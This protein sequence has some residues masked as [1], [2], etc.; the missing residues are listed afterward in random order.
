MPGE[1]DVLDRPDHADVGLDPVRNAQ[2]TATADFSVYSDHV[3]VAKVGQ[4]ARIA[5]YRDRRVV[6]QV[7]DAVHDNTAR[8]RDGAVSRDGF[9]GL[10]RRD[11]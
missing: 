3:A 2:L 6:G 9:V 10:C 11:R 7:A 1:V 5:V 8:T 4:G